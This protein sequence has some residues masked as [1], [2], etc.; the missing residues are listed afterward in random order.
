MGGKTLHEKMQP[1][2]SFRGGNEKYGLLELYFH[3]E[4][5][6]PSWWVDIPK[7]ESGDCD[8]HEE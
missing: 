4:R 5:F 7:G 3:E 8:I 6:Q 1:F 2:V